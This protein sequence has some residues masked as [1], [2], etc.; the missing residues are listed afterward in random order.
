MLIFFRGKEQGLGYILGSLVLAE[1]LEGALRNTDLSIVFFP[2]WEAG[3]GLLFN[4]SPW[5]SGLLSSDS[6]W[7]ASSSARRPP[8][9]SLEPLQGTTSLG[10]GSPCS[11]T[12]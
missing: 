12:P 1:E 7:L 11:S 3:R 2:R 6:S 5:C 4:I 9:T 10:T 8:S